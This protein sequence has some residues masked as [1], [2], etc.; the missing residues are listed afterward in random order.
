MLSP[1]TQKRLATEIRNILNDPPPYIIAKPKEDNILE[2]HFVITGPEN[3]PF[4]QGQY[5]GI[6][7]FPIIFPLGPPSISIITP[8][9][10]FA[11]NTTLCLSM[12]DYHPD[13]WTPAWKVPS[14]LLGFLSFMTDNE[15]TTGSIVT[16]DSTK[17]QLAK[18]S[19]KWNNDNN[20]IFKDIF[21]DLV[22]ENI[23]FIRQQEG[24]EEEERARINNINGPNNN[25]ENNHITRETDQFFNDMSS[26][27]N[28]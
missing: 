28:P 5:H 22:V 6:M 17:K 19:K 24:E 26:Y 25:G 21:P 7:L 27:Y 3:T 4:S 2:W 10:R 8:N 13:D 1:L 14:M 20:P 9:G 16:D 15:P 23:Q 12:T 18:E 11:C